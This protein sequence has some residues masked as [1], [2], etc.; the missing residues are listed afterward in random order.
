MYDTKR[1]GK[2]LFPVKSKREDHVMWLNLLKVIPQGMPINKTLANTECGEQC[3]Q[4]KKT[5]SKI[6]IL[7]IKISWASLPSLRLYYTAN[8]ALNGFLKYSKI[9]N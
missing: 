2:F 9:F 3:F 1:V 4:I 7:C 6:S 5:S 8:W